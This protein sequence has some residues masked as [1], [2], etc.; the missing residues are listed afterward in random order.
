MKDAGHK[1]RH[2][3]LSSAVKYRKEATSTYHFADSE[4]VDTAPHGSVIEVEKATREQAGWDR[5][6]VRNTLRNTRDEDSAEHAAEHASAETALPQLD[7]LAEQDPEHSVTRSDATAEQC[8]TRRGAHVTSVQHDD[9][10]A[11][12]YIAPLF[13]F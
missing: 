3:T 7:A 1:V 9:P 5:K 11:P 8:A 6:M 13:D 4:P 12:N 2:E 10:E